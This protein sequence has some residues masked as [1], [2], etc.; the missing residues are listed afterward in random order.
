MEVTIGHTLLANA[1][2]YGE[3]EAV[4]I[5]NKR[6]TYKALNEAVNRR[7]NALL[8]MGVKKGDHVGTLSANS[9]E[10]VETIYA[11]ARIGA[12]IVPLNFRLS[13]NE[14]TYVVNHADLSTLIFQE[15]FEKTVREI[16]PSISA[17]K[18][19]LYSGE[20]C[21]GDWID[22]EAKT[23]TQSSQ[24]P[25][26]QV[27]EN[28]MATIIYTSGTTGQ[29]KGVVHTHKNWVWAMASV[30][31]A[32]KGEWFSKR[33]TAFPLFHAGGFLNLFGSIFATNTLVMLTHFDAKLMIESIEKEKINQLG[34]PPTVYKMLLRMPELAKTDVRSIR[35]IASGSEVMPDETRNQLKKAFPGAGIVENYG[36]TETCATIT[37]RVMEFT[38][39]KPFSAGCPVAHVRLR[40]VD[41]NG[42]DVAL[43][44]VG[45][46][47][48]S[49]PN[50]MQGY[51]KDKEKTAEAI[52]DGW[53]YTGDIGLMDG[54]GFLYLKDRKNNMLI[55]GGENI[56]PKEIEDVL[57][58][59]PK[60]L[61]AAVFGVPD[62]LWGEKVCAAIISKPGES[63]TAEDVIGFCA[64]SLASFKKPKDVYFVD[65]LP[66]NQIGKVLRSAL[67]QKFAGP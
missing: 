21:S 2:N 43:G 14:M 65:A 15:Q 23:R 5:D 25:D 51:Y 27:A 4:V 29:P 38:D 45:E 34:N 37:H 8:A 3:R 10:L 20:Q 63:L 47:L 52:R 48:C 16:M 22:F 54:D 66:K 6:L 31:I 30:S 7:A 46:V 59:H 36:M 24:M 33:L 53:L 61:E 28:D 26:V 18:S 64:N 17:V 67:K 44:D 42:N 32:T 1:H 35:R 19:F 41:E 56:Y 13:P 12:V 50:I 40:I 60:I 39:V 62:E 58:R 55:S 57:Y 49:G 11:L 9:V